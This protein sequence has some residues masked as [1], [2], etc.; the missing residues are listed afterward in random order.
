MKKLKYQCRKDT[1]AVVR[2]SD[3]MIIGPEHEEEWKE[4]QDWCCKGNTPLS[5]EEI[6]IAISEPSIEQKL[7]MVGL[8][9]D[10]LKTALGIK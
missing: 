9:L 4:Y 3:N 7:A 1:D 6:E 2:L 10:D 5:H 8:S